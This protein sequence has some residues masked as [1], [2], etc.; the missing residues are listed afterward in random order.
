LKYSKNFPAETKKKVDLGRRKELSHINGGIDGSQRKGTGGGNPHKDERADGYKKKKCRT[1]KVGKKVR[2]HQRKVE[3][4]CWVLFKSC[5]KD[6]ARGK[7]TILSS[8]LN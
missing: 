2:N 4:N 3:K 7:G 5:I 1:I 8:V 6:R